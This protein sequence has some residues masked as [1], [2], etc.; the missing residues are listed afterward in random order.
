MRD[1]VVVSLVLVAALVTLRRPAFGLLTYAFLGFFSP[2]SYTWDFG[3]TIPLSMIVAITTILSLFISPEPKRFPGQREMLLLILLWLAYGLSTIFAIYPDRAFGQLVEVSKI[4]LMIVVATVIINSK[5]R[6][7]SLVKVISYSLGF[8]ALKCG[9][10][11]VTGGGDFLVYGPE[12]SFLYANNSIGLALASNIPLLYYLYR[13]E[14][15]Y[16]IRRVPQVM[17]L[18][19]VPATLF[20]YSRGAWLGLVMALALLFLRL[21]RKFVL[22]TA[23]GLIA[24]NLSSVLSYITPDRLVTRYDQLVNYEKDESAESRFWN[25]E[26]CR[27]V[28][29]ARLTGGGFWFQSV[30]NYAKYYP[31]FLERWP[32]KSWSCHSMWFTILGDHG[33]PGFIIWVALILS[34]LVS[35]RQLRLIGQ[36]N[37][38]HSW[39]VLFSQSVQ[40]SF[41]VFMVVGTF[42]DAAYFDLLYYLVAMVVI[43]KGLVNAIPLEALKTPLVP[44]TVRQ[45]LRSPTFASIK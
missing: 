21:K 27:R 14:P 25:W 18:F 29:T 5:E 10:S 30:E 26:F 15:N 17:M 31:E 41:A 22:V 45:E 42:L 11:A 13:T 40:I 8:Y 38:E 37:P 9:V 32:G 24:A 4:L 35:L 12:L 19:S 16:W 7:H 34:S 3:R 6:L 28:G 36:R 1:I 33:I 23:A 2:H 44:N 39:L 43:A 20:T